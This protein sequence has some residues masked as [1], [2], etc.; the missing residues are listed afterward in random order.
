M[1]GICASLTTQVL[2]TTVAIAFISVESR[3]V[4]GITPLCSTK[5]RRMGQI[6]GLGVRLRHPAMAHTRNR[7]CLPK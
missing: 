6:D 2:V 1:E 5:R 4:M 3:D 7:C